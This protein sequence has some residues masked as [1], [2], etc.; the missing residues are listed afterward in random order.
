MESL[1]Q[2]KN[3]RQ[4]SEQECCAKDGDKR[5]VF[6]GALGVNPVAV[7]KDEG[8]VGRCPWCHKGKL[9]GPSKEDL[10]QVRVDAH[11]N[12]Y[13][14]KDWGKDNTQNHVVGH[15]SNHKEDEGNDNEVKGWGHILKDWHEGA[16]NGFNNTCVF[17]FHGCRNWEGGCKEDNDVPV[18]AFCDHAAKVV[19][20]L[21][22]LVLHKA[23][24][25]DHNNR[26]A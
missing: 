13:G 8:R 5:R 20:W 15:L 24:E 26:S 1:E 21:L 25:D 16:N 19:Q 23:E 3:H 18:D 4:E 9:E 6:I 17:T 22:V 12:T 11:I 10:E 7:G 14:R 2:H